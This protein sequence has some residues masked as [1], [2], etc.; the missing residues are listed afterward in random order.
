MPGKCRSGNGL[1]ERLRADMV[2]VHDQ[3]KFRKFVDFFEYLRQKIEGTGV[4]TLKSGSH[5]SFPIADCRAFSFADQL[6]YVILVNT[7]WL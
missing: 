7:A 1:G 2:S 6:P 5:D 4:L 3:F